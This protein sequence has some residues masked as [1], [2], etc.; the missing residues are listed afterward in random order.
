MDLALLQ[1]APPEGPLRVAAAPK[2]RT[3]GRV[4]LPSRKS[5]PT[6]LPSWRLAAIVERVVDKLK[7]DA[8][9]DAERTAGGLLVLAAARRDGADLAGCGK[10]LGGLAADNREI[11]VFGRRVFLAAASCVTSPSAMTA[12]ALERMSSESQRADLD[13]HLE[14]LAEQ[15]IADQYARLVAPDLSGR[16]LAAAHVALVDHI[17]VKQRRGVH[18]LDARRRV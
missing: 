14:G 4:I 1:R 5:S 9:I 10:E 7:G 17:V 11:V 18:E 16:R 13:H 15:E 8:E 12:A 6:F 2:A 3:T